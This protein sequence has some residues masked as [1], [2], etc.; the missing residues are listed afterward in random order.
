MP[1]TGMNRPSAMR[2]LM[3][4]NSSGLSCSSQA[5]CW[6]ELIAY[7]NSGFSSMR[8]SALETVRATLR[9]VSRT[10]HNQA[11]SMCAWPMALMRMAEALAGLA[12]TPASSARAC[13]TVSGRCSSKALSERCSALPSW[14]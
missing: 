13:S 10:G 6:A 8:A 12:S 11:E 14:K 1:P 5:Y 4:R 2:C 7:L 3:R 9:F